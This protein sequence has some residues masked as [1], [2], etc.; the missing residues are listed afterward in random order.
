M[1]VKNHSTFL[2]RCSIYLLYL[3]ICVYFT[4]TLIII[5]GKSWKCKHWT[6]KWLDYNKLDSITEI[7]VILVFCIVIVCGFFGNILVIC[8]VLTNK[9]MKTSG[10]LFTI[11]LAISDLTLCVFSIPFMTYKALKHTWVFGTK[12][13]K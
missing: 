5:M 7:V 1:K 3:F 11:N 9:H 4:C 6:F 2:I 10:N 12:T 8:T 13:K